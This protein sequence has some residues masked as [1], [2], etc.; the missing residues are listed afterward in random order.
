MDN[1][2]ICVIVDGER[3]PADLRRTYG[4]QTIMRADVE[5]PALKKLSFGS[6]KAK[7]AALWLSP[8]ETFFLLDADAVVWGDMRSLADFGQYDFVIDEPIGHLE[9][10]RRSVMDVDVVGQHF[11]EFD[12]RSHRTEYVNTGAYFG[13]RGMLDVELYAELLRFSHDHPGALYGDQ[14]SFNFMLFSAADAGLVRLA[15]RPLQV[16][17]GRSLKEDV[18][19]RF[20]I[21]E[22]CPIVAGEPV[23]LHWVSSPKPRVRQRGRDYFEPMTFFR[24]QFR[25]DSN[26][27]R[28]RAQDELWLRYEDATCTDWRGTNLRG[29]SRK[30]KRRAGFRW[31]ELKAGLRK[32]TPDRVVSA[33]KRRP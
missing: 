18:I 10:V 2:P 21:V 5:I 29:R 15:Q 9:E 22:G 24:M 31:A 14:G 17:T 25:A 30:L 8:F 23:V 12:A 32:R 26:G 19:R 20:A 16:Q 6:L 1:T 4:V 13:R 33:V 27:R 3:D 28:T 11:P 7:N